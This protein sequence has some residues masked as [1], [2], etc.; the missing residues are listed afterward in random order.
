MKFIVSFHHRKQMMLNFCRVRFQFGVKDCVG[1]FFVG[2]IQGNTGIYFR[3]TNEQS[4][5]HQLG[6]GKTGRR[7]ILS[8]DMT[9]P[10]I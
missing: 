7:D 6:T 1:Q 8:R 2:I 4:S 10:T 9:K 3:E 5:K